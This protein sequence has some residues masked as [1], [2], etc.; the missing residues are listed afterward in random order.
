MKKIE[1]NFKIRNKTIER[2]KVKKTLKLPKLEKIIEIYSNK[3][4]KFRNSKIPLNLK[5]QVIGLNFLNEDKNNSFDILKNN[6][7]LNES[8]YNNKRIPFIKENLKKKDFS[9]SIKFFRKIV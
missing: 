4:K 9:N 1:E 3:K 2:I 6:S 5:K 7:L 8:P